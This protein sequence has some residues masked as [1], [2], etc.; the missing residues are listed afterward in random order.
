MNFLP[1][2]N[3][4]ETGHEDHGPLR[5]LV[6]MRPCVHVSPPWRT[7]SLSTRP[8]GLGLSLVGDAPSWCG[9]DTL[10]R[11]SLGSGWGDAR[12]F[13]GFPCRQRWVTGVSNHSSLT[14]LGMLWEVWEVSP[15]P[16]LLLTHEGQ[17][18]SFLNRDFPCD[19]FSACPPLT[20]I[21]SPYLGRGTRIS[22]FLAHGQER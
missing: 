11:G 1:N 18:C 12:G 10:D 2:L 9:R 6:G 3:E 7:G 15:F 17:G 16:V 13:Y 5:P 14:S 22:T 21:C 20:Q 19:V 4:P 8:G